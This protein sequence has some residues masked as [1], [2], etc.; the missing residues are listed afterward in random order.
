MQANLGRHG[1]PRNWSYVLQRVSGLFL[2]AYIT[3]HVWST[4]FSPE[5][6]SG[7][8]DMFGLMHRHLQNPGILVFY[9]LGVVS[10]A[11]HF[12]NG[13]FGFSIHWGIATGKQ[14]QRHAARL[15]FAVFVVLSLVGVNSLLAFI[16]KNVTWF[17]KTA[18]TT[19]SHV[20]EN[21]R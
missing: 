15:A 18:E 9:I 4:R 2:V 5:I 12:G 17:H 1:Y 7:D 11:Y 6:L 20:V 13:L 8:R 10:A 14:A 19:A 3:Y 21:A 16:G